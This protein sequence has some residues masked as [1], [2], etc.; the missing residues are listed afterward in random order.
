MDVGFLVDSSGS[1]NM[2]HR[3]NYQ[4]I[5]DFIKGFIKSVVIGKN[6]TRIGIATYSGQGNFKTRFNFTAYSTTESLVNAVQSIPYDAGQTFTGE[7]LTSISTNLFTV[8]RYEV[9]KILIVLTDGKSDDSV[10]IPSSHLRNSGVHIISVGVGDAD[11]AELADMAS[12]PDN[13]NVYEVTFISLANLGGSLLQSVCNGR[14][15]FI[16][17]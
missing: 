15:Y 7:A 5:K 2:A 4:R 13:G 9:P 3:H 11:Y 17:Y 10:T 8:A 16:F 12:D 14:C 1:I 6:E